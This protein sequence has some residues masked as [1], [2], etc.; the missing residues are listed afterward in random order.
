MNMIQVIQRAFYVGH[1]PYRYN[2]FPFVLI[3]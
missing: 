2:Y 1:N 3:H